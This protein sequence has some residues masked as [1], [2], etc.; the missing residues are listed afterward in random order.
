VRRP[1]WL[2]RAHLVPL[3]AWLPL[4]ACLPLCAGAATTAREDYLTALGLAP[5]ATHGAALFTQCA[6]CHGDVGG[7]I[8]DG[9]TPRIAGQHYRVLVKQLLDFRHGL[10][11]NDSM[12]SIATST[13][14]LAGLQDLADVADY[15]SRIER[16]GS[17]GIGAGSDTARGARV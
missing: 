3:L 7:G 14:G 11:W 4:L 9:T 2:R 5:D 16:Q 15:V 12:E 17:R 10:R 8:V 13:H 6:E 1:P